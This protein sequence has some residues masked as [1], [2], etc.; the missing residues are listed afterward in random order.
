MVSPPSTPD[1]GLIAGIAFICLECTSGT[2]PRN[3]DGKAT[4]GDSKAGASG[5]PLMSGAGSYALEI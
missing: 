5:L 4:V 3:Q 2:Q 1:I